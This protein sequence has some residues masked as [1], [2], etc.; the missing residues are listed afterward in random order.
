MPRKTI[1]SSWWLTGQVTRRVEQT[2]ANDRSGGSAVGVLES[3]QRRCRAGADNAERVLPRSDASWCFAPAG[4][5]GDLDAPFARQG[6]R[7]V[8]ARF[9]PVT[10]YRFLFHA[11]RANRGAAKA[12]AS[13]PASII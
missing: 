2:R 9:E 5:F 11:T 4:A 7:Y 13:F 12:S 10:V 3:P 8:S 6:G 1:R